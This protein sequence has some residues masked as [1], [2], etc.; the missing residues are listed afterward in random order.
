MTD[1][2]PHDE[3]E[4]TPE[5]TAEWDR[6]QA[7][8]TETLRPFKEAGWQH[9]GTGTWTD[10]NDM[11]KWLTIDPFTN[12]IIYSAKYWEPIRAEI[13]RQKQIGDL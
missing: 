9:T 8:L 7:E 4:A 3:G 2:Q 13:E 10:P 6:Q 12:D 11:E 5:E 1:D